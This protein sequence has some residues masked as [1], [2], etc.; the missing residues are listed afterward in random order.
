MRIKLMEC[1]HVKFTFSFIEVYKRLLNRVLGLPVR[2]RGLGP[3]EGT[4]HP[5]ASSM[6]GVIPQLGLQGLV[7]ASMAAVD[8]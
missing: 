8:A 1:K 4:V 2:R 5:S 7:L 6:G 3:G